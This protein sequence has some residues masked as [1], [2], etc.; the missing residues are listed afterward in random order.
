LQNARR[1]YDSYYVLR[2]LDNTEFYQPINN[3]SCTSTST[4]TSTHSENCYNTE[5]VPL[6]L[7]DFISYLVGGSEHILFHQLARSWHS[8]SISCNNINCKCQ[9]TITCLYKMYYIIKRNFQVW[10]GKYSVCGNA[11]EF[12]SLSNKSDHQ[13]S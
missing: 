9:E 10:L 8:P 6:Y 13:I 5:F 7:C 2:F 11:T 3:M 1:F 4:D 12:R